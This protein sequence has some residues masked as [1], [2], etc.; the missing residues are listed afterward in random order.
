MITTNHVSPIRPVLDVNA[1][2]IYMYMQ[3]G[4]LHIYLNKCITCNHARFT[5][6]DSDV[7]LCARHFISLTGE[8][9]IIRHKA[10]YH[11]ILCCCRISSSSTKTQ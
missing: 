11:E 7:L 4:A 3:K 10:V 1:Y 2:C 5:L 6:T 8:S 9:P